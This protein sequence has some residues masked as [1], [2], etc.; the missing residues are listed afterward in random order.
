MEINKKLKSIYFQWSIN[1][2]GPPPRSFAAT[3]EEHL[4]YER[5]Y[6]DTNWLQRILLE[7]HIESREEFEE[8]VAQ[9]KQLEKLYHKQQ[10]QKR[11]RRRDKKS[12]RYYR[13]HPNELPF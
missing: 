13:E 9:I 11:E 12:R 8:Q 6:F 4:E 1:Y 3:F 7:C 5:Y 10:H 2:D